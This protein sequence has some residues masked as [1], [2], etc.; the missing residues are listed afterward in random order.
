M[1][2]NNELKILHI[3]QFFFIGLYFNLWCI[4]LL[5]TGVLIDLICSLLVTLSFQTDLILSL[6][7]EAQSDKTFNH[8]LFQNGLNVPRVNFVTVVNIGNR[9]DLASY[10]LRAF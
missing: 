10:K 7:L 5:T 9:P 1:I 6:Y 3:G 2:E 8:R 4:K